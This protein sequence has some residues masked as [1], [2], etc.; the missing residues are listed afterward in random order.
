MEKESLLL[1]WRSCCTSLE[2][3]PDQ[4]DSWPELDKPS[5]K[6]HCNFELVFINSADCSGPFLSLKISWI[7]LIIWEYSINPEALAFQEEPRDVKAELSILQVWAIGSAM[8]AWKPRVEDLQESLPWCTDGSNLSL[9]VSLLWKF[10]MLR[11]SAKICF[12][13]RTP[14]FIIS[15]FDQLPTHFSPKCHTLNFPLVSGG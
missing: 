2:A 5:S 6:H 9:F 7:T 1:G 11:E 8:W 10:G 3:A 15:C 13:K 4:L 12:F 14:D